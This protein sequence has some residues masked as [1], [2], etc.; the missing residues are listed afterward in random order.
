MIPR[1][2][3]DTVLRLSKGFPIVAI[4]GPRQSGKTT[5]A[6]AVFPGKPYASLEY[7]DTRAFAESDPRAF[8]EGF[9]DGAV[10]DE[11][12]R[13]PDL[14][15]YLQ[16]IVDEDGRMGLFVLTGSQQFDLRAKI[17]QSLAGRAGMVRLL[18]F[19]H[20]E[21]AA[22]HREPGDPETAMY[23]G[24]YPPLYDRDIA[25][26]DWLA[27]YVATYLERDLHQL[28]QVR[29]LNTFQLFLRM[30]AGR[31]G[32]LLN[33]SS[34]AA[35]CGITHNTA[36]AWISVLEASYILYLL[37]PHFRNFNKRLTKTPKLYFYDTGLACWLLGIQ[38]ANQLI[39]HSL[40][41]A[42]FETWVIS[43]LIKTRF[44][45]GLPSN[46]YFWRD[47]AG[48]EIDILIDQGERLAPVEVKSGKT[49]AADFFAALRK[50]SA[51]A[52]AAAGP[53]T[54]VYAGSEGQRRTDVTV[55][56][57]HAVGEIVRDER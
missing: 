45:S 5:L 7:P 6:R 39:S 14:F 23:S 9:P 4:T 12:Q 21:L 34:L 29:D 18:P 36:R 38:D 22:V 1:E 20:G 46:L 31:T 51:L 44:N 35:D 56:P 27:G 8:L 28:I 53:A 16:G 52:G 10:L 25:P 41:G 3:A 17:T 19:S 55:L 24:Y 33:L 43:E 13:C 47:S 57:W 37:P 26:A 54:L 50:W 40:R 11:V 2:A 32:Q 30:C 15:S 48:N 42:L 49:V